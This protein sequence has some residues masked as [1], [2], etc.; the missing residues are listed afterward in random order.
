MVIGAAVVLF[1]AS[2]LDYYDYGNSNVDGPN[3]WDSLGNGI[4]VYMVGVIGAALIVLSRSQPQPRKVAGL[5]LAQFG[6]AAT[7][8]TAWNM[9]WTI[10]DLGQ[11]DAGAGLILGFIASLALAGGAVA[12]PLV[13]ALKA[14]LAGAPNPQAVQPPYGG[15]PG[16]G[17]GYPGGPQPAFGGQ[18]P[19]QPQPYGA[20][21]QGQPEAQKAPAAPAA[22]GGEFTPF[23]FAVPVARQLYGEDGSQAPIAELAP[24]TWYLAV[25]QRGSALIAQTQ[26][27]RR[28]VL[29]DTTGIQRG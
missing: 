16:Q 8:F 10:I 20:Q 18:Q 2:F 28:G 17:Y 4:G 13:P 11:I 24:G 9:F 7:V 12:S 3:S 6:V 26:D 1:I 29:Q 23:W 27:G 21:Q 5:D 22:G 19:G 15:Q 25:E 14:P